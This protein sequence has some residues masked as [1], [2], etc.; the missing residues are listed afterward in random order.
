MIEIDIAGFLLSYSSL[1]VM[2]VQAIEGLWVGFCF[3][4]F[5]PSQYELNQPIE[6][7][8]KVWFWKK[9]HEFTI[10]NM[11]IYYIKFLL[12]IIFV[13][14]IDIKI[15][16][17]FDVFPMSKY[18]NNSLIMGVVFL[19]TTLIAKHIRYIYFKNKLSNIIKEGSKR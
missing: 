13:A 10:K 12:A 4:I 17:Y 9:Y 5:I 7:R 8:Q 6:C 2:I 11:V 15:I 3:G 18:A 19:I 16:Q 14:F 1:K